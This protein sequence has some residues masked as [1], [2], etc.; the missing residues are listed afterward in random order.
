MTP[1]EY[2]KKIGREDQEAIVNLADRT[3]AKFISTGSWPINF[4]IGD[5]TLQDKP[6]GFPCG[7]ITEI[8]GDES[9]GKSTLLLSG[10]RQAQEAGR[11]CVLLDYEQTFHPGYAE[12]LG[13]SLDKKKLVVLQPRHFQ[14]GAR[15]IKDAMLMR[16]AIIGVDSVSAMTPKEVF[17][18]AVD[19]AGRPGLQAQLMSAFL[20]YITK[21]LKESGV[22]LVFTNQLRAIINMGGGFV[23]PG[24]PKDESSGG[25][26]LK[27]YSSVRIKLQKSSV[28]KVDR[29]SK[30]TGKTDK[31]PVNVAIF[32]SIIKNKIDKPFRR[33]PAYI[34]FGEGF[35]NI[36]SI[37]ELA[38]NINAI[39]RSG[40]MYTFSD[41][42]EMLIKAQ[43][44][45]QLWSI[46]NQDEKLFKRLSDSLVVSQDEEVAQQ[47]AGD[48]DSPADEMDAMLN[49]VATGYVE[50]TAAKKASKE[51]AATVDPEKNE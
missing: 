15:M 1:E 7:H 22:A 9:A 25:R 4:A 8:L 29:I 18:G 30:V 33:V 47:Y 39:K 42:G 49:N 51:E 26:A 48:Q 16:P 21:F 43:G 31:E 3:P 40:A 35:D 45:E 13:L 6:G 37:I 19:E 11:L 38:V 50:K 28:E 17:E 24:A 36:K 12:N 14:Q 23:P 20:G 34:R 41:G 5:G 2:Y 10:M 27:F 32:A 46:L 44:K